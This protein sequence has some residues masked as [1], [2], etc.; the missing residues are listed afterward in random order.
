MWNRKEIK[1]FAKSGVKRNYWKTVLTAFLMAAFTGGLSLAVRNNLRNSVSCGKT[2]TE[3]DPLMNVFS[4]EVYMAMGIAV[5]GML[6]CAVLFRVLVTN[7]FAVG[8]YKYSLNAVRETGHLSDLGSGFKIGYKR[9]VKTMFLMDLYTALW[10]VLFIIPGIV[11]AYEYRMI[12]YLLADNPEMGKTE[13]FKT[14]KSMMNG[15]KWN[16]FVLDLSFILWDILGVMTLGL[17]EVFWVGPYKLLAGAALYDALKEHE[18]H[19]NAQT[20]AVT[21]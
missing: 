19:G 12:P 2:Q 6:A 16:A 1:G 11:K 8:A 7:P 10:S 21:K 5:A 13:A 18:T 3:V 20:V 14:S 9:K 17:V 15:N 4:P